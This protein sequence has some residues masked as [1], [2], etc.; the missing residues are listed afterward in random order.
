M[1]VTSKAASD[2]ERKQEKMKM[3]RREREK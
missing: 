2:V 3:E 1:G